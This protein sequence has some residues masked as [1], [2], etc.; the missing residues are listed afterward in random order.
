MIYGGINQDQKYLNEV[1]L[2][3]LGIILNLRK[4]KMA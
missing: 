2:L 4:F 1:W 3:N